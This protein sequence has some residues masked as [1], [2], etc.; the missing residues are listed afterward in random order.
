VTSVV[1]RSDILVFVKRCA[2]ID[3]L[4]SHLP[5]VILDVASLKLPL[6]YIYVCERVGTFCDS[7]FHMW[8]TQRGDKLLIIHGELHFYGVYSPPSENTIRR[9][10]EHGVE[11]A[12][13][14]CKELNCRGIELASRSAFFVEVLEPVLS[15]YNSVFDQK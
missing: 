7:T 2:D 1:R 15:K 11:K 4:H 10:V 13:G 9:L 8:L 14:L 6:Y 5:R 12:T 3:R